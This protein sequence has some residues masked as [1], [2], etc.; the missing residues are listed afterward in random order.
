VS[1]FGVLQF[2]WH[3]I[4]VVEKG[5]TFLAHHVRDVLTHRMYL[6]YDLKGGNTF[7]SY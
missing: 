5:V 2:I 6:A 4:D 1:V 3:Y 7:E